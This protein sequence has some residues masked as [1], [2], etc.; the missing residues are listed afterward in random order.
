ML[1]ERLKRAVAEHAKTAGSAANK[2]SAYA[3][4]IIDVV[5]PNQLTLDL[6][7]GFMPVR[8]L[9]IGDEWGRRVKRGRYPVRTMVP[10]SKHLT[11]VTS[12]VEQYATVF[13]R[14]IAGTSHSLWE[15]QSGEV[16][17]VE[18]MRTDLR[19]DIY[20]ELVS[21]VFGILAN[22]WNITDTPDNF[23]DVGGALTQEALDE[24]I[25]SMMDNGQNIRAIMGTRRALRPLYNFAQFREFELSGTGVDAVGFRVDEAFNEFTNSRRVSRYTGIPVIELAQVSSNMLAPGATSGNL[26]GE[27]LIPD[28]RVLVL[29]ENVG[30]IATFGDTEYQDYTDPSTQ[31]P[32]YVLHAWQAYGMIVDNLQGIG[33]LAVTP[34]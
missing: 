28:N 24:M 13:D 9:N 8:A 1:D 19:N 4:I 12:Y 29:S 6:F 25:E 10:G 3:E 17:T 32:N 26:R 31:P 23:I 22:A 27:R 15:I 18:Q 30:Q 34:S 21:K 14:L 33:V 7:S 20:S 2:K 16:G 11:D 5:Q